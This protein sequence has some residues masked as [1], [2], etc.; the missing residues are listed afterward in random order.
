VRR[1]LRISSLL[2]LFICV[3]G[4]SEGRYGL[5]IVFDDTVVPADVRHIEVLATE[6]QCPLPA[7]LLA[8]AAP[9]GTIVGGVGLSQSQAGALDA[10]GD[11]P[12]GT[13]ALYARGFDASCAAI[14]AGCS[15][16]A[17][18]RGGSGTL[19]VTLTE[20]TPMQLC[21]GGGICND[22]A[23]DSPTRAPSTTAAS[24]SMPV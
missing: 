14:A 6:G 22:G 20:T 16:Y 15:V 11:L 12:P 17:V 3:S 9:T 10:L 23:C 8:G 2:A 1:T 5:E 21:T 13:Y 4:C 19:V 24:R 18:K 7:A